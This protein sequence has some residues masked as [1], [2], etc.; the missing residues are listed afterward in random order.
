MVLYGHQVANI[1]NKTYIDQPYIDYGDGEV[2]DNATMATTQLFSFKFNFSGI[3]YCLFH[4]TLNIFM[5][6]TCI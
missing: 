3:Y 2:G 6:I 5:Y 1:N 4:F